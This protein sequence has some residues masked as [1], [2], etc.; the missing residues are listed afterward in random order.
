M[1]GFTRPFGE[2]VGFSAD[3]YAYA[4]TPPQMHVWGSILNRFPQ[5][6]GDLFPGA[7][8]LLAGVAAAIVWMRLAWS[9]LRAA[10]STAPPRERWLA[11]GLMLLAGRR[12]DRRR[13]RGDHWRVRLGRRRRAPAHDQRAPYAHLRGRRGRWPPSSCRPAPGPR[14]GR[15]R[16]I[17]RRSCWSPSPSAV[18]MSLGPVPRAGGARLVGLNLYETFFDVVPGFAGLRAPARFGMVAGCLLAA[19]GGYALARL[20]RWRRGGAWRWR[21]PARRSSPRPT[22]CPCPRT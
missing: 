15:G 17:S 2:V 9:G 18:V 20:E 4:H 21:W 19:L 22:P 5:A 14:C 13:R 1:L 16:P 6:E 11:R 12:C 8:P 10:T 7:V 3:L